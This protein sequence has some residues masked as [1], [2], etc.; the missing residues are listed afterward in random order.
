LEQDP[1]LEIRI[2]PG[3]RRLG[4]YVLY[5]EVYGVRVEKGRIDVEERGRLIV[6]KVRSAYSLDTLRLNPIIRAYRD[7]MWRLGIDPTKVRPS[8]EA[9]VRRIL[10]TGSFP[11]VNNVVDSGNFAS[12]E[13]LV[14]LGLYDLDRI[15]G[16]LELRFASGGE[17]FNPIGRNSERLSGSE[18][19]LV[20]DSGKVLHVYPYR[21]SRDTMIKDNTRNVLVVGAGVPGVPRNLVAEA[22]EKTWGYLEA[23]AQALDRGEIRGGWRN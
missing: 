1:P 2:A 10:R 16:S 3:I 9:L 17:V 20:D 14:S 23:Y 12:V 22:L 18:V 11:H 7:F 21:D 19:V 15:R 4:A 13:T 6:E 5:M 8:S